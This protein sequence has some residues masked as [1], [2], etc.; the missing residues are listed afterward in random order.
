MAY[1]NPSLLSDRGRAW[2]GS[3]EN[4]PPQQLPAHAEM[5]A[6]TGL[7]SFQDALMIKQMADQIRASGKNE[8]V[9]PNNVMQEKLAMLSGRPAPSPPQMP[10]QQMAAP[11]QQMP[12][13]QPQQ[14]PRMQGGL[15]AM[16]APVM[17][18]A[19]Y[20]NG[21][22]VAFAGDS[23]SHVGATA[24]KRSWW[25]YLLYGRKGDSSEEAMVGNPA[26]YNAGM[27]AS[28]PEW[29]SPDPNAATVG[30]G[31]D[32]RP[33]PLTPPKEGATLVPGSDKTAG[34]LGGF[35]LPTRST[36]KPIDVEGELGKEDYSAYDRW[37]KNMEIDPVEAAKQKAEDRRQALIMFGAKMAQASKDNNFFGAFG[38]GAEEYGKQTSESKKERRAAEK[39]SKIARMN[40]DI[41]KGS[42]K[43]AGRRSLTESA[44]R[45]ESDI[46]ADTRGLAQ[47]ALQQQANAI[48]EVTRRATLKA[49]QEG[50]PIE[51][52]KAVGALEGAKIK[53]LDNARSSPQYIA[54]QKI[55][56]EE[57][58][59]ADGNEALRQ[60]QAIESAATAQIDSQLK[61]IATRGYAGWQLEG[62]VPE[63]Q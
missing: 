43:R 50:L 53:V 17:D 3:V 40:L 61:I 36:L 14:D 58:G 49:A 56:R 4:V 30:V 37:M 46:A 9:P 2:L 34:G 15:G 52:A 1:G 62:V 6:K 11:Q 8:G 41:G 5:A 32:G 60:M 16:P 38:A 19:Q 22:I 25:D 24:P 13:P 55:A 48:A 33:Y 28:H 47:L 54:W 42:E 23:G 39:E 20:A 26:N 18:N 12:Q 45:R 10:Q 59:N 21:G 63:G 29:A 7:M 51:A 35:R 57:E 27:G 31:P 44:Y